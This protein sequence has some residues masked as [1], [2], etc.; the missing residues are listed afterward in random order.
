MIKGI[1]VNQGIVIGDIFVSQSKTYKIPMYP[2]KDVA[3][4][5]ERFEKAVQ[6][7]VVELKRMRN[8]N[9][10]NDT[11]TSI[12]ETHIQM[13]SDIELKDKVLKIMQKHL[14]NVEKALDMVISEFI[15]HFKNMEYQVFQEKV[16]DLNDVKNKLMSKL[17]NV[18]HSSLF[19]ISKPIVLVCESL[20]PGDALQLDPSKI[21]G[22]V[23]EQ[24]GKTSHTAIISKSLNI[25]TIVG[26]KDIV[27]KVKDNDKI[28][29]D[30]ST[31][32]I[33][34]HPSEEVL[35]GYQRLKDA[36]EKKLSDLISFKHKKGYS[37]DQQPIIVKSNI[38]THH[39]INIT[40]DVETDGVGLYRTEFLYMNRQSLPSE[41]EQFN[42]YSTLL[43]SFKGKPVTVRTLDIGGDKA[44]QSIKSYDEKNPYLGFRG[45]RRSLK[46]KD[47]FKTQLRALLRASTY[48]QLRIMFPMVS[49]LEELLEA[50]SL[51]KV[52]QK[53]LNEEHIP[54]DHKMLLGAMI[55]VP[56]SA[57][58]ADHLAKEVDF[59]SIGTNDLIQYMFAADRNNDYINY[60]YQTLH[61]SVLKLIHMVVDAANKHKKHVSVC[62]EMAS[63]EG[64]IP[65]LLGLGVHELSVPPHDVL[66]TKYRISQT[67]VSKMKSLKDILLSQASEERVC[68]V[69]KKEGL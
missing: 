15:E 10:F 2:I 9:H 60:L 29:M 48:G 4:E 57:L 1:G 44:I 61:P 45:I 13:V 41:E 58:I 8:S 40:L 16:F 42:A 62:G 68:D 22:I 52:C 18:S 7:T 3:Y 34:I 27:S 51:L 36:Y 30:A 67:D 31:G 28:V 12:M 38:N 64:A 63:D 56:S 25:P 32:D 26:V 54:F 20:N 23:T 17:L 6:H 50:K 33:I 5:I 47:V 19:S 53:E 59:L 55:E 39:D 65:I 66:K 43:K 14:I 49:T 46:E 35:T 69:L 11:M 24:G 37:L 21:L